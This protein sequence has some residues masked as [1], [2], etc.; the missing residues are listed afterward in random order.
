MNEDRQI[1]QT[2]KKRLIMRKKKVN[3]SNL[4]MIFEMIRKTSQLM[5]NIRLF[6]VEMN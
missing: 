6:C 3:L 1:Q 2:S 4:K 5:T